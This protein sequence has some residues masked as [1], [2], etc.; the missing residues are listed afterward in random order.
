MRPALL[1][2]EEVAFPNIQ[3]RHHQER[4]RFNSK[5]AHDS[6]RF[7]AKLREY[8]ERTR[9]E[10]RGYL[11]VIPNDKIDFITGEPAPELVEYFRREFAARGLGG[12]REP[13]AELRDAA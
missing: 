1:E 12:D 4:Q 8:A 10:L 6:A 5:L 2:D 13:P 3:T 9:Q 7:R 11:L